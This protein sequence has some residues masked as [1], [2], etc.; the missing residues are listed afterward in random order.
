M[1]GDSRLSL[2]VGDGRASARASNPLTGMLKTIILAPRTCVGF[3]GK[4]GPALDAIRAL[5]G[6]DRVNDDLRWIVERLLETNEDTHDAVHF[7]VTHLAPEHSHLAAVKQGTV[8]TGRVK[9][10]VGNQDAFSLFQAAY[11]NAPDLDSAVNDP[12]QRE[13]V[14]NM[15]AMQAVIEADT[16]PDVADVGFFV[17]NARNGF[18]YVGYYLG[19]I[20][21]L[22]TYGPPD[23]EGWRTINF[24]APEEGSYTQTVLTAKE[25]GPT[26]VAIHISEARMGAIYDP[27]TTDRPMLL[28]D[29]DFRG[30]EL[31]AWQNTGVKLEGIA[32]K[33]AAAVPLDSDRPGRNDPCWCRSAVKYKRC[34]LGWDR[35]S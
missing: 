22:A 7:V 9:N 21:P 13:Q 12:W 3:A 15:T 28:K 6:D 30:F 11:H 8:E 18:R 23:E 31:A 32:L 2:D 26:P 25:V 20:G 17:S 10:W 1:Y 19:H 33:G 16:M 29:L 34:H 27:L 4:F 14:R 35:A 5:A 24:T